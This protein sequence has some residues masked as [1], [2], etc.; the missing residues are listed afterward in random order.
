MNL[1]TPLQQVKGLGSAKEG[2][3][4]WWWQRLTAIILLPIGLWFV[5]SFLRLIGGDHQTVIAWLSSPWKAALV[6]LFLAA[7]FYHAKLGM[8]IVI[9]DYIHVEWLKMTCLIAMQFIL[10]LF[11]VTAV[12]AV[13]RLAL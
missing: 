12:L 8:Q 9:E 1:R 2:A 3:G 4:H 11:G 7:M 13:L 5:F 10:L 6:V